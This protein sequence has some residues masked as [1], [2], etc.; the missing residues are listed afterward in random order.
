M[1]L[2]KTLDKLRKIAAKKPAQITTK[3]R[4]FLVGL[5][6]D[7]GVSINPLC[8]D[9]YRDAAVQLFRVLDPEQLHASGGFALVPG[10]DVIF[11]GE[12]VCD[13]T[14]TAENARRW[15]AA[16]LRSWYFAKMPE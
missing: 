6:A 16:G 14:L 5:A 11:K 2:T 15:L 10:T 7:N 1:E 8:K 12:R 4:Q 9:C 3:E 13:A